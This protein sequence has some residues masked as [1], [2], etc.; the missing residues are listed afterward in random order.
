MN[1]KTFRKLKQL[2]LTTWSAAVRTSLLPVL[3]SATPFLL[4]SKKKSMN[5]WN[6]FFVWYEDFDEKTSIHYTKFVF[7]ITIYLFVIYLLV[8]WQWG[9]LR[10]IVLHLGRS[11]L[12]LVLLVFFSL[13]HSLL[14]DKTRHHPAVPPYKQDQ[15]VTSIEIIIGIIR[16]WGKFSISLR[17]VNIELDTKNLPIRVGKVISLYNINHLSWT[18]WDWKQRKRMLDIGTFILYV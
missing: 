15:F 13:K 3:F 17:R 5:A 18:F 14:R 12:D 7:Y 1:K 4:P 9:Y 11:Y 8:S 6:W 16:F 10:V 2:P